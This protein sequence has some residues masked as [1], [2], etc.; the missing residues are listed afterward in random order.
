MNQNPVE[1]GQKFPLTIRRMGING[2]GIGYF[3]KAVV[4]VPGAITGEEVVVE[5]VKVRDRF[6]E[7]KLNKIRKKSPNRVTAPCPVYEACGGCQLQ[8]VAYSAQLELKRDIVI[9]SIEKHTKIDPTKLKIRPTIGMEDPWRYRNKSQFQTRMVGSGQVETGLFGAN[10]HQLVPI[11]DCIVQQPVTIKVT[12]F[13]RDL[14]EK[15]GVPIYDEKAGSGIVRTI[16]VRSGVKTGETQLVFITNSKKLPKKRE[17]L[18]EIEAALPEVTSIMQNVNQ[19]KS[20]LIFGDETFLLAGKESIEEKLME[21]EFDLSARAFFQ[22]NPFQT[23]RLY[24]EVEKA[25]V[26]T[27]SETLVDAYCGVGTIG[28]AFA[29]KVKEV[30]GMDIIPESIEDAKRNAEKNGIE[31]VYYEVGK[32]EDVLPKWV[33]EGF[34]PDAVIVDPPRSGC[35]QG[36]IKSLLDVEAK[37]L[38]YVSCNPST[39][40]RDLALLAKKYRI[41]YMQPVDMFPQTAHVETVVLLQLKDK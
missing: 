25:L 1:E 14:L 20:S 12:N 36:L 35:D 29:G 9:Q 10:S 13:V 18:A 4:F 23:E 11:E 28:Q 22:L 39:L 17:M 8:H 32:A 6:T 24:Q 40:A 5:A 27:G 37:Q 31:N 16:V 34:R 3:K 30:R 26:L 21:L 2:E 41:R 19:A 7:A 15:Y 38:V 33:N